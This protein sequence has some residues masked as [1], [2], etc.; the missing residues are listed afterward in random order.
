MRFER[1][2]GD[3]LPIKSNPTFETDGFGQQSVVVTLASPEPLTRNSKSYPRYE[4][5]VQQL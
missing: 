5:E 3:D 4:D 2:I 1:Q